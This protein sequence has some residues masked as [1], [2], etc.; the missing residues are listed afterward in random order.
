MNAYLSPLVEELKQ[1]WFPVTTS[2]GVNVNI[3]AA[4][5]CIACDIPA[6][7]TVSGL[8]GHNASLACNKCAAYM[9]LHVVSVV[10]P[11]ITSGA[12]YGYFRAFLMSDKLYFR[13]F[14]RGVAF[15]KSINTIT[16]YGST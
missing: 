2:E 5:S 13:L 9:S 8:I 1:G 16:K 7:R 12:I 10:I 11:S 3:R 14:F 4:L 6:S 15:P